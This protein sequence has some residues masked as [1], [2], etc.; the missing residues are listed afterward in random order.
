MATPDQPDPSA[1]PPATP[2]EEKPATPA[3]PAPAPQPA[4]RAGPDRF[5]E[6]PGRKAAFNMRPERNDPGSN[7]PRSRVLDPR[8]IPLVP[9]TVTTDP[10][11]QYHALLGLPRAELPKLAEPV[12]P[13]PVV[14]AKPA[15]KPKPPPPPPPPPKPPEAAPAIE[16]LLVTLPPAR[17]TIIRQVLLGP[18]SRLKRA[19]RAFM[20]DQRFQ[21]LDFESQRRSLAAFDLKR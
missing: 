10:S 21:K 15:P 19:L 16:K 8:L 5:Q 18:E 3:E 4:R 6:G 7:I 14:K 13:K 12:P 1:A 2:A 11:R 9:P 20:E 17:A